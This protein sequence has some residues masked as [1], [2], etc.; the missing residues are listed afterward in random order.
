[1]AENDQCPDNLIGKYWT[2]TS[3]NLEGQIR[4]TYEAAEVTMI[5][6]FFSFKSKKPRVVLKV[7]AVGY[8]EKQPIKIVQCDHPEP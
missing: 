8:E 7:V 4:D 5:H 6:D 2:T 3:A 1:M